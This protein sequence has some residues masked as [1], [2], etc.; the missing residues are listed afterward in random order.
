MAGLHACQAPCIFIRKADLKAGDALYEANDWVA[1]GRSFQQ[2]LQLSGS[3]IKS[4]GTQ[5]SETEAMK[6]RKD[7][8]LVSLAIDVAFVLQ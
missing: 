5:D 3:L 1:F 4:T 2:P 6:F 8:G 7:N